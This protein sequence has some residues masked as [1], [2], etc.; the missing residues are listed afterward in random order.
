MDSDQ[1]LLFFGV[2]NLVGSVSLVAL[3]S[4]GFINWVFES[5]ETLGSV[6][7]I[8]SLGFLIQCRRD[9]TSCT[10]P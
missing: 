6:G 9:Q 7:V 3:S 1:N 10:W 5:A 4:E 8:G 2:F